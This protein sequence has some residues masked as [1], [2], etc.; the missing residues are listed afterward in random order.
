METDNIRQ[1][2]EQALKTLAESHGS[3]F[4]HQLKPI[5][6]TNLD[7]GR[8]QSFTEGRTAHVSAY[9]GRVANSFTT[10]Q[11]YLT[12]LRSER[13][14]EVWAPL[15][16]RMQTW[17]YNFFLRKGFAADEQT[18]ELAIERATEAALTILHTHFPYD[19]EFDPWAHIIV[20]NTCRKH[21]HK[22]LKKSAV[23][24]AQMVE[25]EENQ[26][27]PADQLLELQA[28]QQETG[29]ELDTALAQLSEARRAVI[30]YIYFD[31]LPP[32][33]VA[34]KLSKSVG[35][36]YSLQFHALQD[37]RKILNTIRDNPN[38]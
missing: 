11:P 12:Q 31:E 24:A 22:A 37:L 34:Q 9:V 33:E 15:F 14:P 2:L 18:R 16:E 25:L 28:L 30:Q 7:R 17:A 1:A 4:A 35:A 8:I 19:T 26:V 3:D 36:I 27:N 21:I 6:F 13:N 32:E 38:E 20:Q 23:P 29:G 5:L 10:L